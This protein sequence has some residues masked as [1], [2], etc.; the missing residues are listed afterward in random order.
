MA[1]IVGYIATSLDGFI[2]T[3]DENLAWLT[4][5]PTSIWASTTIAISS[6]P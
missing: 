6:R 1:R 4:S 2:A 5:N 3:P